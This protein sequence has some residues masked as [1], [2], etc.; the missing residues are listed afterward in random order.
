MPAFL[1]RYYLP[2]FFAFGCLASIYRAAL[3]LYPNARWL[4]EPGWV[5]MYPLFSLCAGI[6]LLILPALL[7]LRVDYLLR[8]F[9]AVALT[10]IFLLLPL[11]IARETQLAAD[12]MARNEIADLRESVRLAEARQR[13]ELRKEMRDREQE[14]GPDRYTSYEGKLP[15]AQL[16]LLR[17][18]DERMRDKLKAEAEAYRN[19]LEAN[20]IRGPEEWIRFRTLDELETEIARQRDLYEQTR[21]F[22]E[23]F[24]SFEKRYL[25]EIEQAAL[26]PAA[27][28]VAIA[29]LERVLQSWR[30]DQAYEL[31]KLD[32]QALGSALQALDALREGWGSWAFL[33]RE[34]RLRFRDPS[35]EQRFRH[36]IERLQRIQDEVRERT[37]N[38]GA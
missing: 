16:R 29:E 25:E 28:R 32:L 33:P 11:L 4:Q 34:D 26:S 9:L 6:V 38:S 14:Q 17:Q 35:V 36:G 8:S 22:T 5:W 37:K 1:W 10:G 18:L 15:P 24:E 31:R 2:V 7:R 21:R 23:F 19:A 3:G 20:P 27:R 13:Q 12:A 30:R